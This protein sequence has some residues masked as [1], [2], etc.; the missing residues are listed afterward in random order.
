[1]LP[2]FVTFIISLLLLAGL[3]HQIN[4]RL[5]ICLFQVT[6]STDF[7]IVLYFLFF[8]PGVFVHEL[9]HWSV[10]RAL[11]LKTGKFTV[12]PKKRGRYIQLGSVVVQRAGV[13]IDSIVGVAP[14]L[15]GSILLGIISHRVLGAYLVTDALGSGDVSRAIALMQTA[16]QQPDGWLW[17]YLLFSIGNVMMP[18]VSDREPLKPLAAYLVLAAIVYL[19]I[20]LPLGP[21]QSLF[22]Y[23]APQLTDLASAFLFISL[24]DVVALLI[25]VIVELITAPR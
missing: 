21:L 6:R 7:S 11:G 18:S 1:M 19:L 9:A 17:V 10:A 4:I 25:L 16:F 15:V 3:S 8:L 14:L 2:T 13:W 20:G 23:V 5:Q 12:W 22:A 24:I